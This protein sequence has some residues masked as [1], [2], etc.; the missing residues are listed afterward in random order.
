[1]S[2]YITI[3]MIAIIAAVFMQIFMITVFGL[4]NYVKII[5]S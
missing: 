3:L 5:S 1:M 2:D 4:D